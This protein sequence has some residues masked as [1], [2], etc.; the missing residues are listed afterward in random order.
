MVSSRVKN[1]AVRAIVVLLVAGATAISAA[2]AGA[3]DRDDDSNL[4]WGNGGTT[5]AWPP[6]ENP[7]V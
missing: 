1:W 7:D 5:S 4:H 6:S 2:P 3:D